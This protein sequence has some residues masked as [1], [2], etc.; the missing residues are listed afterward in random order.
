MHFAHAYTLCHKEYHKF[1]GAFHDGLNALGAAR[2]FNW[3]SGLFFGV[4]PGTF[5][6][7]HIY[8]HHK[9]DNGVDD[10]YSTVRFL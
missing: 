7:A 8:N 1:G 2:V 6:H 5:T 9:Y 10:Q 4:L 3:W